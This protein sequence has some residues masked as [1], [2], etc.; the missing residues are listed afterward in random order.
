MPWALGKV[1]ERVKVDQDGIVS[2]AGA[3]GPTTTPLIS[4]DKPQVPSHLYRLVGRIKYENVEGDGHLEM[5]NFFSGAGPFFSKTLEDGGP[6]GKISGSS[7]WRDV[8]LPFYSQPGIL[9]EKIA[10][11]LILPAGGKVYLTPLRLTAAHSEFLAGLIGGLLGTA[12]GLLGGLVGILA[13]FR[14][15]RRLAYR[16]LLLCIPSGILLAIA[17]LVVLQTEQ[18]LD[19]YYPLLLSGGILAVVALALYPTLKRRLAEDEARRIQAL[20]A[21]M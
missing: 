7:D 9:P 10:V 8:E 1:D 18:F 11:A 12:I 5:L 13:S 3:S 6:L 15:S 14:G 16:L 17:G 2:I 21:G 19:W 20:D 4:L